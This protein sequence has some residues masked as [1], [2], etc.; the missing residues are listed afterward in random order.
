[1]RAVRDAFLSLATA[2]HSALDLRNETDAAARQ[3]GQ[4]PL[5]AAPPSGGL[6]LPSAPGPGILPGLAGILYFR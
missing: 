6:S 3:P 1:M 4:N 2:I 5:Q